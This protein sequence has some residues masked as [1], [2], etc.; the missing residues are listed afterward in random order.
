MSTIAPHHVAH[1]DEQHADADAS[2]TTN[3]SSGSS[4]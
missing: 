3:A 1:Q 2:F 4:S